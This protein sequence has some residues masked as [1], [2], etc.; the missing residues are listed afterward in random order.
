MVPYVISNKEELIV[1]ATEPTGENRKKLWIKIDETNHIVVS[2]NVLSGD[3]YTEY[4]FNP[5]LNS[6]IAVNPSDTSNKNI[7][8]ETT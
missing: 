4:T 7:W 8:I 6:N 2:F 3:S 5:D 1:S